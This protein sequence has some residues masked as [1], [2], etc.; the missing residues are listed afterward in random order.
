VAAKQHLKGVA[1]SAK[2][3]FGVQFR[4]QKC[5]PGVLCSA[6][7]EIAGRGFPGTGHSSSALS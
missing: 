7:Q 3:A 6:S 5:P 1:Y 2:M 4:S